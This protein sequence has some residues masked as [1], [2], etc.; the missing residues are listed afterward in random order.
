MARKRYK[1]EETAGKLRQADVLQERSDL[2]QPASVRP[3]VFDV[4][5]RR[6]D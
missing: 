6:V 1:P 4:R 5:R 2:C 3:N